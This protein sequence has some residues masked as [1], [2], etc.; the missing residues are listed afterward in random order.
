MEACPSRVVD[1]AQR[2]LL[3]RP[4]ATFQHAALAALAEN[5]R[6]TKE[7]SRTVVGNERLL[8]VVVRSMKI[9]K[10]ERNSG[11]EVVMRESGRE[12]LLVIRKGLGVLLL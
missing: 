4:N 10:E 8:A 11:S 7:L 5:D 6:L 9:W 2:L 3:S 1:G 12:V